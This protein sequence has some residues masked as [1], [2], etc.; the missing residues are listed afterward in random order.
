[1]KLVAI[2]LLISQAFSAPL[3]ARGL[4]GY[5]GKGRYGKYG[6]GYGINKGVQYRSK[7]HIGYGSSNKGYAHGYGGYGGFGY[8]EDDFASAAVE[9]PDKVASAAVEVP[10]KVAS[11]AV[12]VPDKAA[13]AAVEVPD[14]VSSA[15]VEVPDEIDSAAIEVP[16]GG[17]SAA[18]GYGYSRD[19]LVGGLG[20]LL[21]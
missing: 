7:S 4:K 13:S 19:H 18:L 8:I 14:E 21:D 16:V 10:E 11:A 20:S 2:S 3:E 6:G 5:G 1:M 17:A 15:A 12:E 9:A